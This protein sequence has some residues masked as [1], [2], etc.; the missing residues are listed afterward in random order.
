V[1]TG[2][3]GTDKF[4]FTAQP[5]NAGDEI[6]G[7]AGTD[8]V[9]L[10]GDYGSLAFQDA[11]LTNV[12]KLSFGKG[13]DYDVTVADG[14]DAAGGRFT[15]TGATLTAADSL[16]FDGS[17]E[18]DGWFMFAGGDGADTFTGGNGADSIALR[19]GADLVRYTAG[20]QSTSTGYD[21]ITGFDAS[22]DHLHVWTGVTA[23][24]TPITTGA[25][26]KGSF[27]ANLGAAMTGLAAHH[28]VLFEAD[29]GNLAG[30]QFLVID[31]NG[32]AGYQG[33]QDLVV[34]LDGATH[35]DQLGTAT[36][37]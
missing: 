15:V 24:D 25:L 1:L 35:L 26:A 17:A 19:G 27:D 14:N 20:A 10:T 36:F 12:E 32:T 11:T 30:I 31:A 2:T 34:R 23:V 8:M 6:D 5:F 13:H 7:G 28:A 9:F 22:V 29:S 16:V 18:T 3:A 21:T 37:A 4:V 33:G